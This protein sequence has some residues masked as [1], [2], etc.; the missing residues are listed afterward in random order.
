MRDVQRRPIPAQIGRVAPGGASGEEVQEL[1]T[2]A[3]RGSG[4]CVTDAQLE[5][6]TRRY[7]NDNPSGDR[8]YDRQIRFGTVKDLI[9]KILAAMDAE[10]AEEVQ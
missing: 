5:A 4:G 3:A 1:W 10:R 2:A 8:E 6:I 7:I 9:P